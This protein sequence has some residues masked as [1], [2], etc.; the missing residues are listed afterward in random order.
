MR[1]SAEE[2]TRSRILAAASTEI[3][4][5][6]LKRLT[7][8]GLAARLGMSHANV[9][10]YFGGKAG[11]VDGLLNAWLRELEQRLQDIVDGPDPADDKLER[12]LTTLSRNYAETRTRE[13]HLLRLLAEAPPESTEPGRH[14]RRIDDWIEKI[15]EEGIV[16]RVFA[17]SDARRQAVLASDLTHR[18]LDPGSILHL[19][20]PQPA[21]DARRDRA[22]RAA[23]RALSSRKYQ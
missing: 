12:F 19:D 18:F 17:G 20:T 2:G 15:C 10:R 5:I 22:I 23:I 14:R 9:Y 13:L 1:H 16:T 7:I 6:G 4:Q 11:I 8:S 21:S 3:R